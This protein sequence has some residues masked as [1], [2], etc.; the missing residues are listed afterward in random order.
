MNF[1]LDSP[2]KRLVDKRGAALH[3][4]FPLWQNDA[5]FVRQA[6]RLLEGAQ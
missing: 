1:G 5:K 4:G 2:T 6:S 3:R